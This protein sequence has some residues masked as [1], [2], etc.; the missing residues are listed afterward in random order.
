[1]TFHEIIPVS[2]YPPFP[3][4][5]PRLYAVDFFFPR[6]ISMKLPIV[7][8]YSLIVTFPPSLWFGLEELV[9]PQL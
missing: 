2:P 8:D 1:L 6:G 9:C 5:V 7:L 3:L 4:A